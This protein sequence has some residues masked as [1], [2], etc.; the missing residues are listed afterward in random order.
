MAQDHWLHGFNCNVEEWPGG[1]RYETLAMCRNLA[2]AREP[3]KEAVAGKP[4][5]R[6]TIRS[7]TR[8]VKRRQEGDWSRA[9]R[10]VR[11]GINVSVVAGAS[12]RDA[13]PCNA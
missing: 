10:A 1:D 5:G 12:G 4:S 11:A 3:F 13:T 8:V 7:R 9:A 2:L 6:F